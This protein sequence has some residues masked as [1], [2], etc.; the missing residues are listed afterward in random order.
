[1][2]AIFY[3]F[4]MSRGGLR[5]VSVVSSICC[6]SEGLEA[7]PSTHIIAHNHLYLY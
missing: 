4:E 1:M 5:D 2:L 3:S 7:I 6:F